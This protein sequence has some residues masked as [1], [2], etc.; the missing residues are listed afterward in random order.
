MSRRKD[1]ACSRSTLPIAASGHRRP[2]TTRIPG[3]DQSWG[4][5]GLLSA[6]RGR[7][8]AVLEP[9][10]LDSYQPLDWSGRD[11]PRR[12]RSGGLTRLTWST[13]PSFVLEFRTNVRGLSRQAGTR[14]RSPHP[15]RIAFVGDSFTEA[16]QV[17]YESTFCARLETSVEPES[18]DDA[19]C[20]RERWRVGNR[21]ARLLAP[22]PPRRACRRPSR[23]ARP[24]HLPRQRLSR[25][26]PGRRFRRSRTVPS[27]LLQEAKLGSALDRLGQPPFQVRLLRAACAFEHRQPPE[28]S[29]ASQGPKNWWTDPELAARA[30][31]APALRRS[32]SLFLR[33]R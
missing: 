11:R 9:E 13:A 33:D 23:C 5:V 16:M 3:L 1:S 29:S 24:V 22:D 8:P 20:L 10:V 18:S 28:I 21:P 2:P 15:Y 17:A 26:F 32:R 7:I 31:D 27:R 6:C 12:A 4:I 19:G 14:S 25:R 30:A